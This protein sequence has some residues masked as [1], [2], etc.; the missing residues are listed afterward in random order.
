MKWFQKRNQPKVQ[1]PPVPGW[2]PGWLVQNQKT[3]IRGAIGVAL[4][5]LALNAYQ[6]HKREQVVEK[7]PA[8]FVAMVDSSFTVVKVLEPEKLTPVEMELAG[9]AQVRALIYRLRYVDTKEDMEQLKEMMS[10]NVM[11][12]AATKGIQN[13]VRSS[14]TQI[15]QK[16]GKRYLNERAINAGLRPGERPTDGDMLISATWNESVI[17]GGRKIDLPQSGEFKVRKVE[18]LAPDVRACNPF[19]YMIVDYRIFSEDGI[20]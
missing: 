16:R 10:C 4:G 2:A 20:G 19:G 14:S 12:Q 9:A 6:V 11:G 7:P 13:F 18:N 1:N 15:L 17:D 3:I 8:V 5:S